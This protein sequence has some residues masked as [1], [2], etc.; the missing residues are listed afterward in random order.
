MREVFSNRVGYRPNAAHHNGRP[1][2]QFQLSDGQRIAASGERQPYTVI[3]VIYS[4]HHLDGGWRKG[5][6]RDGNDIG[7]RERLAGA[8]QGCGEGAQPGIPV[9]LGDDNSGLIHQ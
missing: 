9:P 6:I 7:I 5:C 8:Q 2:L 1:A 3:Q 4:H